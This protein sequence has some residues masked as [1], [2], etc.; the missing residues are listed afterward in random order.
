MLKL[1]N[2]YGLQSIHLL[3][4]NF[5]T[6]KNLK[7]QKHIYKSYT[8]NSLHTITRC[9]SHHNTI[10]RPNLGDLKL[11]PHYLFSIP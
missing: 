3:Y 8:K 2:S 7:D 9:H 11:S 10:R 4:Q 5:S 6:F 1:T